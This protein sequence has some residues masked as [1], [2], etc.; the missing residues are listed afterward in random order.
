MKIFKNILIYILVAIS[1]FVCSTLTFYNFGCEKVVVVGTSMYPTLH[2]GELGIMIKKSLS[3][4]LD[5]NDIIVFEKGED[6]VSIVKRII[7]LPGE[8]IQITVDGKVLINDQEIDQSYL[9]EEEKLNTY[10]ADY[11]PNM[12]L[13]LASDEYY[14]MGDHRS[15]SL[16]S[17]IEGPV[18]EEQIQGKLLFTYAQYNNFDS[19][20]HKGDSKTYFPFRFF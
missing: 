2:E 11:L 12:T 1:L 16:D 20:T 15:V 14:V 18:K 6:K 19:S 17:R 4:K 13:S 7:G 9:Q 10:R 3:T 5:R 8:T